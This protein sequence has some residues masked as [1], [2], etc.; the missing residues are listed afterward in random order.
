MDLKNHWQLVERNKQAT[1]M[2]SFLL[3]SV[4]TELQHDI[5][6]IQIPIYQNLPL[7]QECLF[8]APKLINQLQLNISHLPMVE[9][10]WQA[11]VRALLLS[12]HL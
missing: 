11:V 3:H 10:L 4:K 5:N 2:P 1:P 6:F 8:C 7:F 9:P 12:S